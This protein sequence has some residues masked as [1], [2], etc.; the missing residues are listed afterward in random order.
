MGFSYAEIDDSLA[1]RDAAYRE[2]NDLAR[3]PNVKNVHR[4]TRLHS[5][6][7]P[8]NILLRQCIVEFQ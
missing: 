4:E 1:T 3:I 8:K 2:R 6:Q 7:N 5:F